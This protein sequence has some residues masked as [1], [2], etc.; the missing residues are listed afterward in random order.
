MKQYI[1][2]PAPELERM[3]DMI[4]TLGKSIISMEEKCWQGVISL[5]SRMPKDQFRKVWATLW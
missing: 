3:V 1:P 5:N 2:T 4:P